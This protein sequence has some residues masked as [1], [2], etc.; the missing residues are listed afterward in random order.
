MYYWDIVNRLELRH[1]LE[2]VD[3]F[4]KGTVLC[5]LLL[6]YS[7]SQL[8]KWNNSSVRRINCTYQQDSLNK[9]GVRRYVRLVDKFQ[10][11]MVVR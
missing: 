5:C 9:L 7:N 4:L 1:Y 11:D 10:K 3:R 8:G 6:L 2:R